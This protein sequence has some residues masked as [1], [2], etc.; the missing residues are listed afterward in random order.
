MS[1]HW[2]LAPTATASLNG[3]E[4][5]SPTN[6]NNTVLARAF[7]VVKVIAIDMGYTLSIW[8]FFYS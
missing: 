1:D 8:I 6:Q 3:M 2:T 5:N 4:A 7:K